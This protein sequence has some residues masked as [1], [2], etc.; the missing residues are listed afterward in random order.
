M[1]DVDGDGDD[2]LIVGTDGQVNSAANVVYYRNMVGTSWTRILINDRLEA[3][4]WDADLG[5][6]NKAQY[7]GR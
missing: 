2:D 4:I 7:V 6:M 1:G 5:D 3:K